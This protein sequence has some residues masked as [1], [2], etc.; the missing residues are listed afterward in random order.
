MALTPEEEA[1]LAELE[2]T[3]GQPTAP[4]GAIS[5]DEYLKANQ[6]VKTPGSGLT[7]EQRTAALQTRDSF[8]DQNA[9]AWGQ[10]DPGVQGLID[11]YLPVM[12][13]VLAA[14][15]NNTH[16]GG[17]ES[18]RA[19]W[20]N[21]PTQAAQGAVFVYE[22]PLDVVKKRLL[23]DAQFAR[24]LYPDEPLDPQRI[25][26][27]NKTSSEY[28]DASN[29][30]W[31]EAADAAAASGKRAYRFSKTP[32][33]Q[34]G[35]PESTAQMLSTNIKGLAQPA[36]EGIVA[37]V[38][39]MDDTGAFGAGRGAVEAINPELQTGN[40]FLGI[41]SAGGIPAGKAHE[42]FAGMEAEH[43]VS[44]FAGQALATLA[45]WGLANRLYQGVAAGGRA[46]VGEGASLG[47]RALTHAGSAAVA[48][49][50]EAAI[51]E[52]VDA[53]S[54]AARTGSSGTTL[55]DAGGRILGVGAVAGAMGGVLG[56]AAE[57]LSDWVEGGRRF[58][59]LPRRFK[60]AG[61][62]FEVGRGPVLPPA[63]ERQ[64]AAGR[65]R[66]LPTVDVAAE[67]LA[68]KLAAAENANL[69]AVRTTV[70]ERNQPFFKTP[71][72]KQRI[73]PT[74]L[75]QRQATLLQENLAPVKGAMRPIENKGAQADFLKERFND[76]IADFSLTPVEGAVE[77]TPE[78]AKS[79]LLPRRQRELAKMLKGP[80]AKAGSSGAREIDPDEL[81]LGRT[82]DTGEEADE[83]AALLKQKG[84]KVYAVPRRYTAEEH[85]QA[86]RS[87]Q[88]LDDPADPNA[89]ERREL[90][91]AALQDRDARSLGGVKGAWSKQQQENEALIGAA[92]DDAKLVAPGGDAFKSLVSYAEQK[93]GE[94]PI[95]EAVR[96]SADRAGV[97]EQANQMRAINPA[98]DLQ[99]Q[100]A[101]GLVSGS[102]GAGGRAV[103]GSRSTLLDNML[104]RGLYPMSQRHVPA[105]VR[106]GAAGVNELRER[107]KETEEQKQ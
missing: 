30:L 80:K 16:P 6:A 106:A 105:G 1:E 65:A 64:H 8:E 103:A 84:G 21:N 62:T 101:R 87:Y 86:I 5:S 25:A 46:L 51:R 13:Q 11:S 34:S 95:V 89:R 44:H 48:G 41:E 57:G 77:L 40:Q 90:Y 104:L 73:P 72:G 27:L 82:F 38:L 19:E 18:A 70:A 69:K 23:E 12:P 29:L 26:E 50:G 96:R 53:A 68:P 35:G 24:T 9:Q 10:A 92:Q 66:D 60:Q 54:S 3:V 42:R 83:A 94:L 100:L 22:P 99:D 79:M 107:M 52:G 55:G 85:E 91:I 78:Q 17:E 32:W 59:E 37:F 33:L 98:I 47:I 20:M 45:P 7:D 43:P 31:R 88:K 28:I 58:G 75:F 61:G 97:R 76:T 2:K 36:S 71:E 49:A 67:G 56:G 63:V 74:T 39:G 93:P 81:T 15:P 102:F 4:T 14:Q